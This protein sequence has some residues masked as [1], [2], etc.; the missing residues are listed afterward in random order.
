MLSSGRSPIGY[1]VSPSFRLLRLGT[2]KIG[3]KKSKNTVV[4]EY[5]TSKPPS[6]GSSAWCLLTK[7]STRHITR[8]TRNSARLLV[9][10][11]KH[12]RS[13]TLQTFKSHPLAGRQLTCSIVKH[14]TSTNMW[15]NSAFSLLAPSQH[16]RRQGRSALLPCVAIWKEC[17]SS[18]YES[19][20]TANYKL[21]TN[22]RCNDRCNK[23]VQ[24]QGPMTKCFLTLF[25]TNLVDYNC[26]MLKCRICSCYL[27]KQTM[28][29]TESP[30]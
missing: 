25:D 20:R 8:V 30:L 22:L 1:L 27:Q 21:T 4:G 28:E 18:S 14:S 16:D 6:Q 5:C 3:R 23:K 11:I 17:V 13:P 29:Q 12:V 9:Q 7:G 10:D 19:R 15:L 2:G 24:N 26:L